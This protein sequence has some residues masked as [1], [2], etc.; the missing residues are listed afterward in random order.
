MISA[1]DNYSSEIFGNM[2]NRSNSQVFDMLSGP[3][4][5]D[6]VDVSNVVS[7]GYSTNEY[8][9]GKSNIGEDMYKSIDH[10]FS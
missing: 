5:F 2:H 4:S 10:L 8:F 3:E 1:F 7:H 6:S 9:S